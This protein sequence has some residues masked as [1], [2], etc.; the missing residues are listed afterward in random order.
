[1]MTTDQRELWIAAV[2]GDNIALAIYLDTVEDDGGDRI[3][4]EWCI[5]SAY[6]FLT[7][8]CSP[9]KRGLGWRQYNQA[10]DRAMYN[11]QLYSPS[12]WRSKPTASQMLRILLGL[13]PGR[14]IRSPANG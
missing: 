14:P 2:G 13:G 10:R 9:G 8:R 1:M 4:E 5:L 11:N 3:A 7:A 12:W 6:V